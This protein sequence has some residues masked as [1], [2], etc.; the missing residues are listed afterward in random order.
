MYSLVG[1]EVSRDK[2]KWLDIKG[3][4]LPLYIDKE[5]PKSSQLWSL[6]PTLELGIHL[7]FHCKQHSFTTAQV[8]YTSYLPLPI[9][10]IL[11]V[12]FPLHFNKWEVNSET[13]VATKASRKWSLIS[14]MKHDTRKLEVAHLVPVSSFRRELGNILTK[15]PA[16]LTG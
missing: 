12:T 8:F 13:A 1:V 4:N 16:V 5:S 9:L 11:Y 2:M 7:L 6:M 15:K 14:L 3:T 10:K